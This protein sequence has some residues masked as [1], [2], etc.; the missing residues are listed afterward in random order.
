MWF[1]WTERQ[2]CWDLTSPKLTYVWSR[3]RWWSPLGQAA[4]SLECPWPGPTRPQ[5]PAPIR[6]CK[7]TLYSQQPTPSPQTPAS[8]DR[9]W[10][11]RRMGLF[12]RARPIDHTWN[13]FMKISTHIQYMYILREKYSVSRHWKLQKQAS[14]P[15]TSLHCK[16][17]S[18]ME[19]LSTYFSFS[20]FPQS[21][22][23][24]FGH[25]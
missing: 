15:I 14:Q 17:C 24:F 20:T 12:S 5:R 22:M 6:W 13:T 21:Q 4:S 10:G 23:F 3:S 19:E 8:L 11:E 1:T 18:K 7:W 25:C 9:A 16:C 2:I